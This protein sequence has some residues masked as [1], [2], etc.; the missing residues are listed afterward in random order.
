MLTNLD[1]NRPGHL[2]TTSHVSGARVQ[3]LDLG[4]SS[5]QGEVSFSLAALALALAQ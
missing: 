5:C 1:G 2:V 3:V 4:F